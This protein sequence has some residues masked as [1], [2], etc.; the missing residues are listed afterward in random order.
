M[1]TNLTDNA[2]LQ[3]EAPCIPVAAN[4]DQVATRIWFKSKPIDRKFC[5][6]VT[7]LQLATDS[8]DQGYVMDKKAGSWTWFELVILQDEASNEP[9]K[10]KD[11]KEL[12]WRSHSNRLGNDTSTTRHFGAVFDRR[13][14]L[15]MN[16]E[17]GDVLAVRVCA[18]FPGWVNYAEN[19]YIVA[20]VLNE[21]LF[22]PHHWT[23][24]TDI[25]PSL[26]DTIQDG[27]Y[28]IMSSTSC[29]VKSDANDLAS[30]IWFA[31]AAL[32]EHAIKQL[33]AVQL[34][35]Y[36]RCQES[37][38]EAIAEGDSFSWFDLVVLETPFETTPKV[39]NGV[40]LV[41]QSHSNW[42][43][44]IH[45]FG[46][47]GQVFDID[48]SDEEVP[49]SQQIAQIKACLE[50]GNA[51]GV[52]VCA[53]YPGW[54]NFAQSGQ[55]VVRISNEN[56]EAPPLTIPDMTAA[57][58][59]LSEVRRAM[60]DFYQNIGYSSTTMATLS[61][62]ARADLVFAAPPP[63]YEE[64]PRPLR[65]LSLDGG[66]V[67]GVSSLRTLRKIMEEVARME[68]KDVVKPCEYF[69]MMAGT[70]TGGLIAL[71]LGRLRMSIEECEAAYDSISR[72]VFG[73]KAGW[74][75]RDESSAFVAGSYMYEAGPLE[76]AIKEIVQ[77]HLG[78]PNAPI[79]EAEPACK[80]LVMSALASAV[81]DANTAVHL[82]N[83]DIGVT[84]PS[85][86]TGWSIW[87]AARA[88]SAAPV[89]FKRFT[90]DGKE[91]VDG[92]LGWNNP[93]YE[94]ISE[95]P[96]LYGKGFN[97]GCI[98]SLG[99]GIPP[100]LKL[101]SGIMSTRDF[102]AIAT[103]SEVPHNQLRRSATLLPRQDEEKY[104]RLNMSKAMS[105]HD[106]VEK[107]VSTWLG[108]KKEV[109]KMTYEDIMVKMDDWE[110]LEMIR[111]L[112]DKWL[113]HDETKKLIH[114]CAARI[115][116]NDKV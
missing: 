67:R 49:R 79:R 76:E 44:F 35:T 90:K 4:D 84:V 16:L 27:S 89:Y 15:L 39:L 10:S 70:S 86:Y 2:W 32:D 77:A 78:D 105:E 53:Q 74:V 41:W 106:W 97:I 56:R 6:R 103:N 9:K 21:D 51:I 92:G 12:V 61:N 22:T 115:A 40:S 37:R 104:W 18:R 71:M 64:G 28:S 114:E 47:Q 55:L 72:R 99:T 62:E 88:T 20:R 17:V 60:K 8:K 29:F 58:E 34:F 112:T 102:I 87:E 31:T 11:G 36:S 111:E 14:E 7:Q 19:G 1:A 107:I 108:F 57:D 73:T 101:G 93:I 113:E 13:S 82:R 116:M 43:A 25:V 110:A 69:D 109:K 48:I 100:K 63:P 85:E 50:P 24:S 52:R 75:I 95:L 65:L 66:G 33:E 98:V 96:A 68:G 42:S 3:S 54:E 30:K 5:F 26:S 81:E 59:G 83:Y 46:I 94:L 91:F 38:K 45:P 23:L 80:V